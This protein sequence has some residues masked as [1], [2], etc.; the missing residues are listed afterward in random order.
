MSKIWIRVCSSVSNISSFKSPCRLFIYGS[1]TIGEKPPPPSLYGRHEL[2]LEYCTYLAKKKL[3]WIFA[4]NNFG[5]LDQHPQIPRKLIPSRYI[6]SKKIYRWERKEFDCCLILFE[7]IQDIQNDDNGN[8][9]QQRWSSANIN[10]VAC[11]FPVPIIKFFVPIVLIFA[12]PNNFYKL[13]GFFNRFR[14]NSCFAKLK[15]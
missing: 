7:N 9:R 11:K 5:G 6:T 4:R 15:L 12:S 1:R 10:A 3:K 14:E 2:P 13:P 8:T